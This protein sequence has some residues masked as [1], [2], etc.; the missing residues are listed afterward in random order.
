MIIYDKETGYSV[1]IEKDRIQRIQSKPIFKYDDMFLPASKEERDGYGLIGLAWHSGQPFN[2]LC[3]YGDSEGLVN[4]AGRSDVGVLRHFSMASKEIDLKRFQDM[5]MVSFYSSETELLPLLGYAAYRYKLKL[6]PHSLF[7]EP[8]NLDIEHTLG[9]DQQI[10]ILPCLQGDAQGQL[11]QLIL[12][13][14]PVYNEI[15]K[16]CLTNFFNGRTISL[17]PMKRE[18]AVILITREGWRKYF[19]N[20]S[21]ILSDLADYT[22]VPIAPTE[23]LQQVFGIGDLKVYKGLAPK[24]LSDFWGFISH[25]SQ[26]KVEFLYSYSGDYDVRCGSDRIVKNSQA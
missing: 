20:Q 12:K 21:L 10:T 8:N 4:L 18:G 17:L 5:H 13:G 2:Q 15:Y 23:E 6:C 14:S 25:F 16:G 3:R 22:A 19:H 11:A 7:E 9:P 26:G 24:G 1:V